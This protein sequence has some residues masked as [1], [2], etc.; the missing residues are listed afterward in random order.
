MKG[1]T[2]YLFV[3]VIVLTL[4]IGLAQATAKP[5]I[6]YC[7]EVCW[8]WQNGQWVC[9]HTATQCYCPGTLRVVTCSGYCSSICEQ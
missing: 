1:V 5:L 8:G 6:A 3:S 4:L 9:G 2:R 7:D